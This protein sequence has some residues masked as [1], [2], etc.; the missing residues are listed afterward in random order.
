VDTFPITVV[1]LNEASFPV[2]WDCC[3][4]AEQISW[5]ELLYYKIGKI[6]PAGRS[7]TTVIPA[8]ENYLHHIERNKNTALSETN[9]TCEQRDSLFNVL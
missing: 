9:R 7:D 5:M 1:D 3:P 6:C 2:L 4:P 8:D